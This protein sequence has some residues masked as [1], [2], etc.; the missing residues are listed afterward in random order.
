[1]SLCKSRSRENITAA[2]IVPFIEGQPTE[3]KKLRFV[4]EKLRIFWCGVFCPL[5]GM[6]QLE[7]VYTKEDPKFSPPYGDG[8]AD[9]NG[10]ASKISFSP[11][12]GD[13]T[14]GLQRYQVHAVF[15]PPYGDGTGVAEWK[16]WLNWFSPPYGDGTFYEDAAQNIFGFSPPYGDGTNPLNDESI[17][18]VFSPPYGDGTLNISQNIVKWKS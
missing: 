18:N 14:A 12:C 2:A 3:N 10:D 4:K 9:A 5:T 7:K 8:T 16:G 6:V 15:S 13:G 1:M 11:P 17:D